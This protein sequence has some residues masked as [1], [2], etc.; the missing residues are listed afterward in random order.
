MTKNHQ[1]LADRFKASI[2]ELHELTDEMIVAEGLNMHVKAQ[3]AALNSYLELELP[4]YFKEK[5]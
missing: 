5:K 1:K 3:A 4:E 2:G